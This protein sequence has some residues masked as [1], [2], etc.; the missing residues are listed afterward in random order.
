MTAS[1]R[2]AQMLDRAAA[3]RRMVSEAW[4]IPADADPSETRM[5]SY[6]RQSAEARKIV[7]EGGFALDAPREL[8]VVSAIGEAFDRLLIMQVPLPAAARE[9]RNSPGTIHEPT[10]HLQLL[11]TLAA[12]HGRAIPV[13]T[14]QHM[15][16]RCEDYAEAISLFYAMRNGH[17]TMNAEAYYAM[18]FSLQR[19]EEESWGLRYREAIRASS[20]TASPISEKA[21]DFIVHG[22]DNQLLPE[23]KPWIGRVMFKD[24]DTPSGR[25]VT[26]DFDVIGNQWAKRIKTDGVPLARSNSSNE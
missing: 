1:A 9:D 25:R 8:D 5:R 10:E 21:M 11:L 6:R 14:I 19:L 3:V 7:E 15:F 26:E 18:I 17:I 20:T 2:N 22:C 23:A 24:T 16:S 13:R 4:S 12:K